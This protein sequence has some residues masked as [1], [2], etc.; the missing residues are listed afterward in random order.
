MDFSAESS[1]ESFWDVVEESEV[2][3]MSTALPGSLPG[4]LLRMTP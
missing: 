2:K 4:S 1:L 3:V